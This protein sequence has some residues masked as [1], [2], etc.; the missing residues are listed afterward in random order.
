MSR[1]ASLLTTSTLLLTL[2]APALAQSVYHLER[3]GRSDA[4]AWNKA[5]DR[6]MAH[7]KP[8]EGI[9]HT[10]LE[11]D[12]NLHAFAWRDGHTTV[13]GQPT[14]S[15]QCSIHRQ[16][17]RYTRI[18]DLD[19]TNQVA[20]ATEVRNLEW[21]IPMVAVTYHVFPAHGNVTTDAPLAVISGRDPRDGF[22]ASVSSLPNRHLT[23]KAFVQ[24]EGV[25]AGRPYDFQRT[26]TFQAPTIDVVDGRHEPYEMYHWFW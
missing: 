13:D 10:M 17:R 15:V 25:D 7:V 9:Y 12:V 1:L 11:N 18:P 24:Y 26:Y 4:S 22:R 14:Y 2:A 6:G 19:V 23:I 3:D 20:I 21:R 5:A 16:P 8:L